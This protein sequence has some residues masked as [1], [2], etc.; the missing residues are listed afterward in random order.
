M[1]QC[2]KDELLHLL[3]I[4][5]LSGFL[6][7]EAKTRT[8]AKEA[9]KNPYFASLGPGVQTLADR[10]YIDYIYEGFRIPCPSICFNIFEPVGLELWDTLLIN[11]QGVLPQNVQ[12]LYRFC[13][14]LVNDHIGMIIIMCNY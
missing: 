8:S 14:T 7:Y 9:L 1:V 13:K 3:G 5:L 12:N 4:S 10:K 6:K 2:S 11:I